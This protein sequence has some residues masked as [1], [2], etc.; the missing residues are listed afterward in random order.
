MGLPPNLM[1]FHNLVCNGEPLYPLFLSIC[2]IILCLKAFCHDKLFFRRLTV[3][4]SS[5]SVSAMAGK[6]DQ[7][8]SARGLPGKEYKFHKPTKQLMLQK[9]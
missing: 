5:F 1:S 4:N 6:S 2:Q 3:I 9:N 7:L 8:V